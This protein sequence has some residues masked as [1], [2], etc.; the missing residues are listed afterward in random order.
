MLTCISLFD[1]PTGGIFWYSIVL[2]F[3]FT[4]FPGRTVLFIWRNIYIYIFLSVL[5]HP[6]MFF[7]LCF[8]PIIIYATLLII[9]V[10]DLD[11]CILSCLVLILFLFALTYSDNSLASF[12]MY[13]PI[14]LA[15]LLLFLCQSMLCQVCA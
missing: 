10:T 6:F 15:K 8:G 3:S 7:R 13:L 9:S 5:S 4:K 1:L 14:L 11:A 12:A 2:P